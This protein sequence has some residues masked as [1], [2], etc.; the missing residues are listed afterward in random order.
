MTPRQHIS[1]A[2]LPLAACFGG[3][4]APKPPSGATLVYQV[5][6]PE[7]SVACQSSVYVG[8]VGVADDKGYVVRMPYVPPD[9]CNIGT[10]GMGMTEPTLILSFAKDGST[11]GGQPEMGGDLGNMGVLPAI[12]TRG[13]DVI[14]AY[15]SPSGQPT[16]G[17]AG[18]PLQP[19]NTGPSINPSWL[20]I[21]TGTLYAVF[22]GNQGAG[23]DPAGPEFPG[24][25]PQNTTLM[26]NLTSIPLPLVMNQPISPSVIANGLLRCEESKRCVVSTSTGVF[27]VAEP[28]S[29]AGAFVQ[30]HVMP[31]SGGSDTAY[32][33]PTMGPSQILT[34]V[35]LDADDTR[36]VVAFSPSA[37]TIQT[38]LPGCSIFVS[39][40]QAPT[41][42][43]HSDRFACMDAALDG[44]NV[45]FTIV[46]GE[47]CDCGQPF[48]IHGDGIG[49]ISLSDPTLFESIAVHMVGR[50]VGPRRVFVDQD[51]IFAVDP[52]SIARI[53]KTA[54]DGKHDFGQ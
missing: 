24:G 1:L 25:G 54:L 23:A 14:Y 45:Y 52:F 15:T 46:H 30:L 22:S 40:G 20:W 37:F 2:L 34:M 9:N 44:D 5:P 12:A 42:A 28:T 31:R 8:A 3:G 17:P 41:L 49:R 6:I 13:S 26:S 47:P 51:G 19:P 38:L 43:F 53:D 11:P 33:F 36:V 16:L 4:A 7:K 32:D 39:E 29:G 35:G 10:G 27:W 48:E 18:A 21:D 50:N